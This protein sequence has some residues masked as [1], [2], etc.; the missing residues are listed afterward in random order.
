MFCPA[1]VHGFAKISLE[2]AMENQT[3]G[4]TG[5]LELTMQVGFRSWDGMI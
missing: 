1:P 5:L 4:I 3:Y 2:V